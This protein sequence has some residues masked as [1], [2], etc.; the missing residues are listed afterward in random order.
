MNISRELKNELTF[1][2]LKKYFITYLFIIGSMSFVTSQTIN[3]FSVSGYVTDK[4]SNKPL[5]RC[6]LKLHYVNNTELSTKTDS[7]GYYVFKNI[8]TDNRNLILIIE[9]AGF[10]SS[11]QKISFDKT[12][13]DTSV[14]I[15]LSQIP[16]SVDWMPEVYFDNNSIV[17][18]SNFRFFISWI[19]GFMANDTTSILTIVGHKDSL[20]TIDL[21]SERVKLVYDSLI[22]RGVNEKR[23]KI[24]ESNEPN[25]V[26]PEI[27]YPN[28]KT[29][30]MEFD[31]ISEAYILKFPLEKQVSL[32]RLNRCVEIIISYTLSE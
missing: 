14:N 9:R 3:S 25:V 16:I 18:D 4:I 28:I 24:Q 20:E 17:P 21:R 26:K 1:N 32:R 11:T 10:Y 29:R 6:Q 31:K 5:D 13:R 27:V 23:L 7:L 8:P 30:K 19:V 22:K 2:L 12:S 15:L